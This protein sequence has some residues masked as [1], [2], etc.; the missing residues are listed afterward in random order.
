MDELVKVVVEKTGLPEA[1]AKKAAEAVVDFL[2]EKLPAP[3]AS[4]VDAALANEEVI[5][6]VVDQ[7]EDL[8]KKGL[9]GF[10]GKK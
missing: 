2:K 8:L 7:A 9:G 1:Q 10:L 5:D 3:L 6:Q 4:Q